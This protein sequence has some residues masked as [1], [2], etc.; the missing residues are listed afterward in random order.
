M[1]SFNVDAAGNRIKG[2]ILVT[3]YIREVGDKYKLLIPMDINTVC[4]KYWLIT[5][6]DEWDKRLSS[7]KVEYNQQLITTIRPN[8]WK[9]V[10]GC[11]GIDKGLHTWQIKIISDIR[12]LAIGVIEDNE[13]VLTA[14]NHNHRFV[15]KHGCCLEVKSGMF[16]HR[17]ISSLNAKSY[18][19]SSKASQ[20][21]I[22]TMT[23]DM[24]NHTLSYKINDKD[25]GIATNTL[26]KSKYR[27]AVLLRHV[28]H[29]IE[30]L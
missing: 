16:Y 2:D 23:L 18:S 19:I 4:F 21:D 14:Y 6:C 7:D 28:D 11:L 10:Y 15:I 1:T 9:L 22:F 17:T 12:F 30:L 27:L 3:G 8:A 29:V 20:G 5:V 25:Y 26:D 13:N 24:D